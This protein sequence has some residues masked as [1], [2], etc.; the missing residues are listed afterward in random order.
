[1]GQTSRRPPLLTLTKAFVPA[2]MA[3]FMLKAI[4]L[5]AMAQL[6]A[7]KNDVTLVRR[8]AAVQMHF[9]PGGNIKEM[10][11]TDQKKT[12][13]RNNLC[14]VNYA[15]GDRNASQCLDHVPPMTKIE[16]PTTCKEAARE[17]KDA[18]GALTCADDSCF[19]DPFEIGFDVQ[20]NYPERCFMTEDGKWGYNSL[21]ITGGPQYLTGRGQ[22]GTTSVFTPPGGAGG[23]EF[24]YPVCKEWEFVEGTLAGGIPDCPSGYAVISYEDTCRSAA[25]CLADAEDAHFQVVNATHTTT[26][27]LDATDVAKTTIA[28]DNANTPY[29]CHKNAVNADVSFSLLNQSGAN[30][31]G[32][33]ICNLTIARGSESVTIAAAAKAAADAAAAAA[34]TPAPSSF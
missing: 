27:S 1:V 6:S 25:T 16:D 9:G 18:T 10:V 19:K 30:I 15:A 22:P 26:K 5:L 7:A 21:D 13:K 12:K 34:P 11:S 3:G 14:T 28:S 20:H 29:G 32:T 8:E 31:A 23:T 2:I 17:M 24:A 33:P 4:M